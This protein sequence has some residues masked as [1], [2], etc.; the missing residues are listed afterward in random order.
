MMF[1]R[2]LCDETKTPVQNAE[3]HPRGYTCMDVY[4]YNRGYTYMHIYA[5]IHI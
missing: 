1:L 3:S 5:I 2:V 4:M